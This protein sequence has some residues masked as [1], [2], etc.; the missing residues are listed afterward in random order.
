[1]GLSVWVPVGKSLTSTPVHHSSL[2][3]Q[4]SLLLAPQVQLGPIWGPELL[5]GEDESQQRTA[6]VEPGV[7]KGGWGQQWHPRPRP[8][9]CPGAATRSEPE[10]HMEVTAGH[11]TTPFLGL[12]SGTS[13]FPEA[14]SF[15][16]TLPPLCSFSEIMTRTQ[17]L[18]LQP[19]SGDNA[20]VGLF[21]ALAAPRP[22]LPS[23][24][25]WMAGLPGLKLL[26]HSALAESP[27]PVIIEKHFPPHNGPI[28]DLP[29][30]KQRCI[31]N[32]RLMGTE[33][34]KV[35][36]RGSAQQE[37][38]GEEGGHSVLLQSSPTLQPW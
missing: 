14:Q 32:N 2:L 35:A 38:G 30:R 28:H 9:H 5:R 16:L 27:L 13:L 12:W 21:S 4:A 26:L 31:S 23:K 17:G 19:A 3:P 25:R 24:R 11:I 15:F 34:E 1:M 6:W 36:S 7:R 8:R 29:D 20:A 33:G 22:K 37:G 10:A 18:A